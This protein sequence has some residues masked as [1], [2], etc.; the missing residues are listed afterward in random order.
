MAKREG[1]RTILVLKAEEL[2]FYHARRSSIKDIAERAG[3]SYP[4]AHKYTRNP[5][6]IQTYDSVYLASF[7]TKGLG[8]T[9]E[10]VRE[11]KFGDVFD[12]LDIEEDE[13][14]EA[15]SEDAETAKD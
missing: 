11:L 13:E 1:N 10:Q 14:G 4:T 8:L 2:I 9:R 5:E 3:A 7:L 6:T 15:G 12:F